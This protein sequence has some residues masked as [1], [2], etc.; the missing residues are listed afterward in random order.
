MCHVRATPPG[1]AESSSNSTW[2]WHA[3]CQAGID[4]SIENRHI[5]NS[6]III[7]SLLLRPENF[8]AP[9]PTPRSRCF[10]I[11]LRKFEKKHKGNNQNATI[12][13]KLIIVFLNLTSPLFVCFFVLFE[14]T[15][16]QRKEVGIPSEILLHVQ[17][18][19]KHSY[20]PRPGQS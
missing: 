12:F 11:Q 13:P 2:R 1:R 18:Q 17:E 14:W 4:D 20:F 5:F 16:S 10:T 15:P 3:S 19:N 8:R 9:I 6:W 7:N